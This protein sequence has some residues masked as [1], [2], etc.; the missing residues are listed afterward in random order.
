MPFLL[1]TQGDST[2]VIWGM[3]GENGF[4]GKLMSKF[5]DREDMLGPMFETGLANLKGMVEAEVT[6]AK[7]KSAPSMEIAKHGPPG[8]PLFR[9]A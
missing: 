3:E 9:R 6:A 8:H 2:R 1:H 5:S 4:W 7:E